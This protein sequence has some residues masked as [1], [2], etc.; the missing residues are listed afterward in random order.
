MAEVRTDVDGIAVLRGLPTPLFQ[1]IIAHELGHVWMVT[2]GITTL[3]PWVEEGLC[4]LLAHRYYTYLNTPESR[5][6]ALYSIQQN[7]HPI[8]GE[9]FREV[10]ATVSRLGFLNYVTQLRANKHP[11]A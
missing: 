4:E 5:H 6:Y 7:P 1:G 2:Q 8:Y 3:A 10:R 11:P 9:G